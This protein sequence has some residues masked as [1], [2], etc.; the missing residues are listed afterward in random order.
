MAMNKQQLE[1]ILAQLGVGQPTDRFPSFGGGQGSGGSIF[2][3]FRV[4]PPQVLTPAVPQTTVL[5]QLGYGVTDPI[6]AGGVRLGIMDEAPQATNLGGKITRF[7]GSALG[8]LGLATL[9]AATF[10]TG[11]VAALGL[12]AGTMTAKAVAGLT[13]SVVLG[14]YSGWTKDEGPE[15]V[16]KEAAKGALFDLALMGAGKSIRGLKAA[17]H[18]KADTLL[19]LEKGL[20][21]QQVLAQFN[22]EQITKA[23]DKAP[24][25]VIDD[26]FAKTAKV[27]RKYD[28]TPAKNIKTMTSADKLKFLTNLVDN[29]NTYDKDIFQPLYRYANDIFL[30]GHYSKAVTKGQPVS[31]SNISEHVKKIMKRTPADKSIKDWKS[32]DARLFREFNRIISRE[33]LFGGGKFTNT[34]GYPEIDEILKN[35]D[36]YQANGIFSRIAYMTPD[37]FVAFSEN[38]KLKPIGPR[39]EAAGKTIESTLDEMV[40]IMK[41]PKG[42]KFEIP[43]LNFVSG[44]VEGLNRAAAAKKA[45][46]KGIPVAVLTTDFYNPALQSIP[47]HNDVDQLPL[48]LRHLGVAQETIDDAYEKA[49]PLGEKKS[50]W[51]QLVDI[52][53]ELRNINRRLNGWYERNQVNSYDGLIK[54]IDELEN[55]ADEALKQHDMEA[56]RKIRKQISK[57]QQQLKDWE[58]IVERADIL[59]RKRQELIPYVENVLRL[60]E[61]GDLESAVAIHLPRDPNVTYQTVLIHSN[62]LH[63]FM[64]KYKVKTLK[65]IDW[66]NNQQAKRDL[67]ELVQEAKRTGIPL[68]EK[69]EMPTVT[70][71]AYDAVH[72]IVKK[73]VPLARELP[74]GIADVEHLGKPNNVFSILNLLPRNRLTEPIFRRFRN[75]DIQYRECKY[76]YKEIVANIVGKEKMIP[77]KA[78][79]QYRETLSRYLEGTLDVSITDEATKERVAKLRELFD[80]LA[81]E[82]GVTDRKENYVSHLIKEYR[83]GRGWGLAPKDLTPGFKLKRMG[84]IPEEMREMDIVKILYNYIDKGAREKFWQPTFDALDPLFG[85]RPRK[86]AKV[87]SGLKRI[88]HQSHTEY[89][90]KLK[91]KIL[92]IPSPMEQKLDEYLE[93]FLPQFAKDLLNIKGSDRYTAQ[94]SAF[95]SELAYSGTLGYNPFSA[96][97][98]LTQQISAVAHLDKDPLTGLDYWWKARRFMSTKEGQ[99]ILER[100]NIVRTG[101]NPKEALDLQMLSMANIPGI[102][103]LQK[104][105]FKMFQW[106]D[107][108]NIDTSWM[109][110][111]LYERDKGYALKEA[112]ESAYSFTMA[113]QFMYGI[114]S[115]LFFKG[116]L[117]K[118]LGMLMSWPINY[119][120]EL[121][122]LGKT[123]EWSKAVVL[124]ASYVFGAE[125]LSLTGLSFRSIHPVEVAKG[126]LPI[127]MLE[128]EE[129]MSIP[130]RLTYATYDALKALASGDEAARA[131]AWENYK[132]AL[133]P[134][135]PYSTQG[136]RILTTLEA[137]RNDFQIHERTFWSQLMNTEGGKGRLKY[138]MSHAEAILGLIGPTTNA[139][140]RW[141]DLEMIARSEAAYRR[142]RAQA[143]DAFLQGDY[144]KFV[145]KMTELRARFGGQVSVA[146]IQQEIILRNMTNIDRRATSLPKSLRM[147]FD[148]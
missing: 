79:I 101:R 17:K 33:K 11:A 107:M 34:T 88:A 4:E 31:L 35:A 96:I 82:F 56:Y 102:G 28:L 26:I 144:N 86:G 99:E 137:I 98:N 58:S 85:V 127:A 143:I 27:A 50:V 111:F 122:Q 23:L 10:G 57:Q 135:I 61:R 138:E 128:G 67:W 6:R 87:P 131:Q 36:S 133:R 120:A 141:Q 77:T 70:P 5:Q 129:N 89:Y 105:A 60:A 37:E 12:T 115:P 124:F 146:D 84:H 51:D 2:P 8:W 81:D 41:D 24:P 83:E 92:G 14:A 142:L 125:A 30:R 74:I 16:V 71:T 64:D 113:T 112:V 148:Q 40:E 73:H 93:R 110:K 108:Q 46:I 94:I 18:L 114:D 97:K 75:S 134:L 25:S 15:E 118:Q 72:G 140:N 13:T 95:I 63:K 76:R 19:A 69:V 126:F 48:L 132:R 44:E 53:G 116:P 78:N 65:D 121:E 42:K 49:L 32:A 109:M 47:L 38:Y 52:E 91:S 29:V 106:A 123:G 103:K 80:I 147:Y 66:V 145:D 54:K 55:L 9:V 59:D 43:I 117:G 45:G 119:M 130:V 136:R 3:T 21:P 62:E 68:I 139:Y 1:Q 39:M 20:D 100:F 104:G 90:L 7:V 22:P